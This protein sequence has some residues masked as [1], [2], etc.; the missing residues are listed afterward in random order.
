[1]DS[2]RLG[3]GVVGLGVEQ[4]VVH[5]ADCSVPTVLAFLPDGDIGQCMNANE[6]TKP[7]CV[8][9]VAGVWGEGAELAVR[10]EAVDKSGGQ[11]VGDVANA[12]A[13]VHVAE[14]WGGRFAADP[15]ETHGAECDF[16]NAWAL[17]VVGFDAGAW[18]EWFFDG[19]AAGVSEGLGGGD[20]DGE[21]LGLLLFGERF[22]NAHQRGEVQVEQKCV[23]C[24]AGKAEAIVEAGGMTLSKRLG[25]EC[26]EGLEIL[27]EW[28]KEVGGEAGGQDLGSG[29]AEG[30]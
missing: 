29:D 6:F 11:N 1:M 24:A 14:G 9:Q 21:K 15:V 23:V 2:P 17:D 26:S 13:I 7:P 10:P 12:F 25:C 18:G 22:P 4:V 27:V 3:C 16:F 8:E 5:D 30:Y 19:V 20:G 28:L